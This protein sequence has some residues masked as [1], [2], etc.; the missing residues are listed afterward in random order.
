[1]LFGVVQS[2]EFPIPQA[3]LQGETRGFRADFFQT[4]PRLDQV[5]PV[6]SSEEQT[7]WD[8]PSPVLPF[9]NDPRSVQIA[10]GIGPETEREDVVTRGDRAD[11]LGPTG[12]HVD[13]V[14]ETLVESL[15]LCQSIEDLFKALTRSTWLGGREIEGESTNAFLDI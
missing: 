2:C 3:V 14:D 8:G 12:T 6:V 13:R 4:Y 9:H 1:M 5:V 10:K 7:W 15:P 11:P